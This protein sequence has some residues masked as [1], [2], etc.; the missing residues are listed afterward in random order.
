[1]RLTRKR[2]LIAAAAT[3][4][5]AGLVASGLWYLVLRDE[6]AFHFVLPNT[7][8]PPV[9]LLDA[10]DSV[11]NTGVVMPDGAEL[12][13][14][15]TVVPGEN[16]FAGYRVGETLASFGANTAVGRTTDVEGH[17]DFDGSA[18]TGGEITVDLTTL[19]SDQA[20]RDDSLRDQAIETGLFP[21]ATFVLTSPV[22]IAI[23]PA[24]GEAVSQTVRG[25]LTL[26]GVTRAIEV[27]VEAALHKGMLV[28]VGSTRIE[29]ADFDIERPVSF[30]VLSIEDHGTLE[31]QLVFQPNP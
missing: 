14:T 8:P 10:L 2:K 6:G 5:A 26:H 7:G 9:S 29:F 17:L 11:G 22:P 1:M 3:L 25:D 21:T 12:T 31:F 19:T 15:W 18:I 13:G 30:S 27:E 4:L 24:G 23:V 16:T 28:V 20:A